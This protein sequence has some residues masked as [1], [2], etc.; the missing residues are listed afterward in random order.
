MRLTLK[1]DYALR[2]LM[3]LGQQRGRLTSIASVAEFYGIS[4]NHLVK[5]VHELGRKGFI[6]TLRGKGGGIRLLLQP[7]EIS[8]GDVVRAMEDDMALVACFG[9]QEPDRACLLTDSCSLQGL[10]HQALQA[11][12]ATLDAHTLADMLG[13][14]GKSRTAGVI[15]LQDVMQEMLAR[16]TAGQASTADDTP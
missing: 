3:Y 4:E 10:L 8:I 1:T 14:A 15:P 2:T 9:P 13:H 6:E 5:V 16:R 12:M 11:F 7:A